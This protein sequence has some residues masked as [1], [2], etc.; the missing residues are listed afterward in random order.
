MAIA[1]GYTPYPAYAG[2][3]SSCPLNVFYMNDYDYNLDDY[4]VAQS[5]PD[6]EDTPIFN[7]DGEVA[8]RIPVE[9][10]GLHGM[11]IW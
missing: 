10:I 3:F 2:F 4:E 1:D 8:A 11:S 6:W 5:L 7:E 9:V